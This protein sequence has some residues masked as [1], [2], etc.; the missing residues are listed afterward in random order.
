MDTMLEPAAPQNPDANSNRRVGAAPSI[1]IVMGVAGSGKTTVGRL[2]AQQMDW[3][4][5]EGDEF[6]PAANISKMQRGHPLTDADRWPW[7]FA[8]RARVQEVIDRRQ[9]AVFTCSALKRAYRDV[10]RLP[11]V[12]FVYLRG[13]ADAIH[14]RLKRRTDHF[15]DRDL[16]SSQFAVLEEPEKALAISAAESPGAIVRKIVTYLTGTVSDNDQ[17]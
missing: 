13:D 6:H 16:L 7:V 12:R 9:H 3:P 4:F 1:V 14:Q 2:L 10:L 8:I 17:R 15:F 11:G 5:F